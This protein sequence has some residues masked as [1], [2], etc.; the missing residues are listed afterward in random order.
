MVGGMSTEQRKKELI[1]KILA[2]EVYSKDSGLYK[3][4]R[5]H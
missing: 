4:R 5:G 1:D 2:N 3:T